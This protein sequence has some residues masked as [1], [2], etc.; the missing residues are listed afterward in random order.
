MV[1]HVNKKF[2]WFSPKLS[3]SCFFFLPIFDGVIMDEHLVILI[4]VD[5]GYVGNHLLKILDAH[6][7]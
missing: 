1:Q 5:T 7:L 6:P 2:N 3:K 4:V